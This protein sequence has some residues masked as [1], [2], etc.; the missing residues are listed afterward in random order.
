MTWRQVDGWPYEVSD[1]G[2]VRRSTTKRI[3][4]LDP[5]Q[6]GHLGVLLSRNKEKR[7]FCVHAL[8]LEAFVG[9]KPPGMETR[10]LD[11]NPANNHVDN[12]VWGTHTQNMHD[13]WRHGTMPTGEKHA[14]ALFTNEQYRAIIDSTDSHQAVASQ[15]GV[16]KST[17]ADIRRRNRLRNYQ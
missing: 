9:P 3:R 13:K 10:H 14:N 11:G 8:V 17:I 16:S 2:E 7:K 5:N 12:L 6:N 1:I 15:Y 4:K